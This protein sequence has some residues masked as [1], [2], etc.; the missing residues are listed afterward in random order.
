[1]ASS[2]PVPLGLHRGFD[3]FELADRSLKRAVKIRAPDSWADLEPA[4]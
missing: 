2:G 1:M 3:F 4:R